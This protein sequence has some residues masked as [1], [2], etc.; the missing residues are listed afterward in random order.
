MDYNDAEQQVSQ[1]QTQAQD[2]MQRLQAVAQKLPQN[3]PDATSARELAMDLREI[4]IGF[5]QQQQQMMFILQQMGQ[6]IQELE[7]AV[8]THPNSPVQTR[9]WG[10]MSNNL[11]GGGFMGTLTTGLGL[12]AG[13]AVGEDLVGDL[14]NLF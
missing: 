7:K 2:V 6:H 3:V 9:G 1:I 14:F 5:K 10:G 11:G 8:D 13:M 12:G 4:A